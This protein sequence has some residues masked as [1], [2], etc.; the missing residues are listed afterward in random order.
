MSRTSLSILLETTNNILNTSAANHNRA[1]N[2][3]KKVSP[4][5]NHKPKAVKDSERLLNQAHRNIHPSN[6]HSQ[7]QFNRLRAKHRHIV[8]QARQGYDKM[9]NDKLFT[10]LSSNPSSAFRTIKSAKSSDSVQVPSIK[11][12]EKIYRGDR[13]ID[14]LFESI[15]KLKTGDPH[16][17]SSSPHH[18]SIMQDYYTIKFFVLNQ[19]QSS[20]NFLQTVNIN[21]SQNQT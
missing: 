8:R 4:K 19:D 15:S 2:L 1:I 13:V 17:L 16:Q 21:S 10:L 3:N 20:S 12:G 5:A 11:V 18:N 7:Q 14:G 9:Q 6:P